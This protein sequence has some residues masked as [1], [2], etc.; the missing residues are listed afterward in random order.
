M[1]LP[2]GKFRSVTGEEKKS[3]EMSPVVG[4][5]VNHDGGRDCRRLRLRLAVAWRGV[6]TASVDRAGVCACCRG[7]V[8]VDVHNQ[9]PI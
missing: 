3:L 5:A 8:C 6:L 7:R 2:L 9:A 1:K 4:V